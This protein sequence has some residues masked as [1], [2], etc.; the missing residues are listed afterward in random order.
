MSQS[1][2]LPAQHIAVD[3]AGLHGLDKFDFW[4]NFARRGV[5]GLDT[6]PLGDPR[7]FEFAA[8]AVALDGLGIMAIQSSACR[9][10]RDPDKAHDR[11]SDTVVVNFVKSGRLWVEQGGR[12]AQIGAGDGAICIA[13]RPYSLQFD[14]GF[15][16]VVVKFSPRL[17][18]ASADFRSLTARPLSSVSRMTSL[19]Y[20]YASNL[21]QS[22]PKLDA[23]TSGRLMRSFVDTLETTLEPLDCGEQS[24]GRR[25]RNATLSR[26]ISFVD[27]RLCDPDLTPGRVAE[28]LKLSPRYLH[29][30]FAAEGTTVGRYIREQRLERSAAALLDPARGGE[31]VTDIALQTGFKDL[32]HFSRSF[33]SRFGVAPTDYR[34]EVPRTAV[35]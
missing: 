16:A 3:N 29:K 17:I 7:K 21:T 4:D 12:S 32:G 34:A 33:R 22:A 10:E 19:L 8:T 25:Y 26:V 14:S 11:W 9:I 13:D 23:R 30:L 15:E 20:N 2:T 24:Q 31:A 28:L 5:V 18:S 1:A 35:E 27:V 6:S